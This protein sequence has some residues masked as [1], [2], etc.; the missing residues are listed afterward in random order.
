MISDATNASLM[1]SVNTS[2]LKKT[3]DTNEALMTNLIEG[4]TLQTPSSNAPVEAP[5]QTSDS[6]GLDIY[7]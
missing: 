2:L 1:L 4:A 5:V 3:M 7:A 6:R